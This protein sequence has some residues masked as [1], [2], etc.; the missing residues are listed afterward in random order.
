MKVNTGIDNITHTLRTQNLNHDRKLLLSTAH[1][2]FK[3]KKS[4]NEKKKS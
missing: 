4:S 2:L 1:S 3:K